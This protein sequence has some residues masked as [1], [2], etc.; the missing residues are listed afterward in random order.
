M[1]VY[2]RWYGKVLEGELLEGAFLGMCQ[3][4][5]PL[6]G[7]KPVA[8]FSPGHVY[9]SREQVGLPEIG[10]KMHGEDGKKAH[11]KDIFAA[12]ERE[13]VEA[14]KREHWDQEH[15]HLCVDKLDEFYQLWR[16][17][18][19][20]C[21]QAAGRTSRH[22]TSVTGSGH[23]GETC[24]RTAGHPDK[25]QEP[26]KRIVSDERMEE[27]K[28]ELKEALKPQRKTSLKPQRKKETVRIVEL[29]L[30]D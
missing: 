18:V 15:G 30:W 9:K 11:S 8:L 17:M 13:R 27:L 12:D 24:G 10:Q 5:I 7:H 1:T 19:T 22:P 4:R 29:A 6:D 16:M 20:P 14:F 25:A 26:V 28:A 2:V 21:G 3:V 23:P